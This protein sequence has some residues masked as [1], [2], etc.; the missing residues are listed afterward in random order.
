MTNL[1]GIIARF[2]GTSFGRVVSA[3]KTVPGANAGEPNSEAEKGAGQPGV[4]S[5]WRIGQIAEWLNRGARDRPITPA[6]GSY[7]G[8]EEQGFPKQ[9]YCNG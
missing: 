4:F 3:A 9:S 1:I 5:A 8:S 6:L 7:R 2:Q